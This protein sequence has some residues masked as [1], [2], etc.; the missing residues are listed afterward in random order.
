MGMADMEDVESHQVEQKH[1]EGVSKVRGLKSHKF[2]NLILILS[3]QFV[4]S[5]YF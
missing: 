4:C 3:R 2:P 5:R 1:R